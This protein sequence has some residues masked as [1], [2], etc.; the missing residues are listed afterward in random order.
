MRM[1]AA[2]RVLDRVR[3]SGRRNVRKCGPLSFG[4]P[5]FWSQLFAMLWTTTDPF[6]MILFEF[7]RNFSDQTICYYVNPIEQV[8]T[9][10]FICN[11][12]VVDFR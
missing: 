12:E 7:Y 8:F 4:V 6:D 2:S 10:L 11:S 3:P 9:Y 5:I 1:D